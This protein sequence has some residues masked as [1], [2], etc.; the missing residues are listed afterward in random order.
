VEIRLKD[1]RVFSRRAAGVPGDPQHPVTREMVEAK[2]RDCVAFSAT[3]LASADI[4]RAIALVRDLENVPDVAEI[5][6]LLTPR[7]A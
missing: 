4:D 6:R 2:F 7:E 5:M 3:P 1:G